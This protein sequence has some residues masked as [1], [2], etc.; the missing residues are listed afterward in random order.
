MRVVVPTGSLPWSVEPSRREKNGRAI[1]AAR[2]HGSFATLEEL[3]ER[4]S[5]G[6]DELDALAEAGALESIV[7]VRREAM[8]KVRAPRGE[9]LFAGVDLGDAAPPMPDASWRSGSPKCS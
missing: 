4:A 5:L 6:R 9:G 8:W 1:A 3:G 7:H 2:K